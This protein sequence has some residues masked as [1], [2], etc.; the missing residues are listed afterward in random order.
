MDTEGLVAFAKETFV[1]TLMSAVQDGQ[2]LYN[3]TLTCAHTFMY[4]QIT[5]I[6]IMHCTNFKWQSFLLAQLL[7]TWFINN[8]AFTALASSIH[9][10]HSELHIAKQPWKHMLHHTRATGVATCMVAS[11]VVADGVCGDVWIHT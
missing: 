5:N 1:E 2:P 8:R 3:Y 9:S 11:D 4:T 6:L 10:R 7:L